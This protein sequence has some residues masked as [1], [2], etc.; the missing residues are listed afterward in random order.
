MDWAKDGFIIIDV[1]EIMKAAY[2]DFWSFTQQAMRHE[3]RRCV[4]LVMAKRKLWKINC[5]IYKLFLL[6][7]KSSE[8]HTIRSIDEVKIVLKRAAFLWKTLINKLQ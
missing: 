3:R 2:E 1:D 5:S 7:R 6:R 8:L 4:L